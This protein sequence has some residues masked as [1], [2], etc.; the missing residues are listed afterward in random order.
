MID[1]RLSTE[2]DV[3][4]LV[5][6]SFHFVP[7]RIRYL[8]EVL[9]SLAAFPVTECNIVVLTNTTDLAEQEG[10]RQIFKNARL[11]EGDD[12]RLIIQ[13]DLAHPYDLTWA[14]KRLIPDQFLSPASRYTHF[15]YLESD[16]RLT[17]ENFAYFLAAREFLRPFALVPAFLRT[18]WDAARGCYVNTDNVTPITLADRPFISAG[19]HA[20]IDL[21]NPYC[22]MFILDRDLAREYVASRSFDPHRSCEVSPFGVRERA[23]MGLTFESPPPPFTNR[24][25][26]PVSIATHVAPLCAWLAH[27]PNNYADQA[28]SLHGKIAMTDLFVG[29]FNLAAA[30]DLPVVES[31]AARSRRGG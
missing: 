21:E 29:N 13:T 6:I 30:V 15:I 2:A 20:F 10:L 28:G 1:V 16:E 25:V 4:L 23:A 22:G 7:E 26:V 18:E 9:C 24:V 27:L 17:F 12:A 11:V 5:A 19:H 8:E 31:D 3:R 14:H